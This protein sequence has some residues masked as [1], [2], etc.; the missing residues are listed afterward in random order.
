MPLWIDSG[1]LPRGVRATRRV[2]RR[3]IRMRMG[4]PS[5]VC[6]CHVSVSKPQSL[7]TKTGNE[8]KGEET[9]INPQIQ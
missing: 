7:W 1:G 2:R 5:V 8:E 6:G 4:M 9:H 3:T